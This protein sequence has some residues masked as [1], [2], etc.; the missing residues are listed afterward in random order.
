MFVEEIWRYP[1][2]SL[3]GEPMAEAEV[4]ELGLAGDRQVVVVAGGRVVTARTRPKLLALAGR[5]NNEGVATINGHPWDTPEALSLVE[6]AVGAPV[7][8]VP[9]PGPERFD[10]LPLLVATDGAVRHLGIDRRRLRPNLV[11]GGVAGLEERG[12][13]GRGLRIGEVEIHAAQ[14]RPR[15]VMTTYDP[16][17]QV[18]DRSVLFRIVK[19]L[20]GTM[21][22]DCSVV[23]TG[24]IRVGDP[25]Q[26]I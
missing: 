8:L 4:T 23:R 11:I 21:A 26:L 14:L 15:C 17:T 13:P 6:D 18:Q 5:I 22:L 7:E 24:R 12:W 19:E 25:V 1:D 20:D 10:I 3:A 2:K 16:D 9:V